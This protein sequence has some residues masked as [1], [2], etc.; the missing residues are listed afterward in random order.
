MAALA[1]L[2]LDVATS[3]SPPPRS[4]FTEE[5][6]ARRRSERPPALSA[7][8]AAGG[9]WSREWRRAVRR[10]TSDP[11]VTR[12]RATWWLSGELLPSLPAPEYTPELELTVSATQREKV[13]LEKRTKIISQN[14]LQWQNKSSRL[15]RR[16]KK[17]KDLN[18][19]ILGRGFQDPM[20]I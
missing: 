11:W 7:S 6:L 17:S 15:Q 10:G 19:G 9:W 3:R 8:L 20:K 12:R 18:S 5:A 1:S 2:L 13:R 14:I 16:Q 4:L